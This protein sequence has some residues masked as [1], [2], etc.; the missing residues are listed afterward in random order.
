MPTAQVVL[1]DLKKVDK[2]F[3]V[4]AGDSESNKKIA[5]QVKGVEESMKSPGVTTG[6]RRRQSSEL[7][8]ASSGLVSPATLY[9][10]PLEKF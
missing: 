1:Q 3:S 2:F 9:H 6:R 4:S 7:S 5:D 10:N 8:K